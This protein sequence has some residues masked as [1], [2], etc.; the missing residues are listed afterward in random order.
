MSMDF[1]DIER[2]GQEMA[3]A[4]RKAREQAIAKIMED[5]KIERP[6]AEYLF[7]LEEAIGQLDN[8]LTQ[9]ERKARR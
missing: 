7:G 5:F 6:A 2:Q 9:L 1:G 3:E 8:R 4:A